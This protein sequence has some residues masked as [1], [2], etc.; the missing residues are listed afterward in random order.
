ME[1]SNC[2]VI[3]WLQEAGTS[4][5]SVIGSDHSLQKV[6]LIESTLNLLCSSYFVAVWFKLVCSFFKLC[7]CFEKFNLSDKMNSE[8]TFI[9]FVHF[10]LCSHSNPLQKPYNYFVQ[11]VLL[12]ASCCR[13]W[14]HGSQSKIVAKPQLCESG[15]YDCHCG[16]WTIYS[17]LYVIYGV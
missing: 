8:M 11:L 16:Y 15:D 5:Q 1:P 14:K 12:S 7:M 13:C 10:A 17:I 3:G 4:C 6:K 2:A 9:F